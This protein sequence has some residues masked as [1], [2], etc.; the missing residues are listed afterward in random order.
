LAGESFEPTGAAHVHDALLDAAKGE[1]HP[2]EAYFVPPLKE[3]LDTGD[4]VKL[5][6]DTWAVVTPRC[7]LANGGKVV[8]LLLVT[9]HLLPGLC[10]RILVVDALILPG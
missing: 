9:R 4:L 2:E 8:S 3:R 7:D 6:E 1:A 10:N 5:G